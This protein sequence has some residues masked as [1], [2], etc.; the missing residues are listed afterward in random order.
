MI[1][2]E[3][4]HF[5]LTDERG[6]MSRLKIPDMN[7]VDESIATFIESL[8]NLKNKISEIDAL[9]RLELCK[10]CPSYRAESDKCGTCGCSST[11]TEAVASPWRKCPENRWPITSTDKNTH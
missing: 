5:W 3:G 6:G 10:S 7:N 1:T 11:M 2:I 8:P 4:D 9:K